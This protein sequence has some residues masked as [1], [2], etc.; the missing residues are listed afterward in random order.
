MSTSASLSP[1]R[2]V[3][4]PRHD[5]LT[6]LSAVILLFVIL[7]ALVGPGLFGLGNDLDS[8]ALLK[9]PSA[10]HWFGT[11]NLGRDVFART[12][13]GSR[14]SLLVGA[15]TTIVVVLIGGFLGLVCGYFPKVDRVLSRIMDGLMAIPSI[16]LAV[17]LAAVLGNG[18][19]TVVIAIAVPEIP[20][21]ARL[22][23]SVVLAIR[24]LP[25]IDAAISVGSGH[26]KIM[27]R[28]ILPNA[29]GPLMVQATFVCAAAILSEAYLGFLG[30]GTPPDVPSW[31][32]VIAGG[33]QFFQLAPW[34]IAFPGVCLSLLVL[35]TNI[36]GD[37]LR[38]MIDPALRGR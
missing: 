38:D 23:R 16:I 34:I 19:V 25:F 14:S 7:C 36:L 27:L 18:L 9:G 32:N 11:D 24:K 17:A 10:A 30:V 2:F 15:G 31:G 6:V 13:S 5:F 33:R 4:L 12:I 22:M 28:H 37:S 35:S 1:R 3:I 29:I 21:M 20:R 8:S 26:G